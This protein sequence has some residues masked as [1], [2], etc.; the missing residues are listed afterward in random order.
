MVRLLV[1]LS[2]L[3]VSALERE[4]THTSTSFVTVDFPM[5][6]GEFVFTDADIT[7]APFPKGV[8]PYA[9]TGF[10]GELVYADTNES[11]PLSELYNHH[12]T[13]LEWSYENALCENGPQYTFGLGAESRRT[14][15]QFPE[16]YGYRRA[17]PATDYWGAN[18]HLLRTEGLAGEPP[19]AAK[20]CNE[21]YYHPGKGCHPEDNGTFACCG[22][23][24][25]KESLRDFV[26]RGKTFSTWRDAASQRQRLLR[27]EEEK[28]LL[29]ELLRDS[30]VQ[31]TP[32][33]GCPVKKGTAL[34]TKHY[35]L[36]YTV[37]YTDVLAVKP[38]EVGVWATPDCETFYNVYANDD[39]PEDLSSTSFTVPHDMELLSALGHQHVG[40]LNISLFV[41]DQF[42]CASHPTY[43]TTPGRVGDELGYVVEMSTCF[44]KQPGAAPLVLREGDTVRVD[45]WYWV[46]HTDSRI[47]PH[48]A[49]SHLNVM[50][51][52]YAMYAK[53]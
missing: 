28:E 30:D 12:W 5:R 36:K 39:Q 23:Y 45:S 53:L 20:E 43:G 19:R 9:I 8:G 24:G 47:A 44:S 46:G 16:G 17:A 50:G 15:L 10:S 22:D 3:S 7:E 38:A 4:V 48:P 49:G 11:V 6:P 52:I 1:A 31:A 27:E 37:N 32:Y 25:D 51:Y 33:Y 34:D 41:N 29:R 26:N 2:A 35:K 13:V 18:I 14:I 21:C 42:V 40:A